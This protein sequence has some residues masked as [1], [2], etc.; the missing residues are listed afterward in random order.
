VATVSLCTFSD[1]SPETNEGS[2]QDKV[3][4]RRQ[5]VNDEKRRVASAETRLREFESPSRNTLLTSARV[6]HIGTRQDWLTEMRKEK[7]ADKERA[8]H[9]KSPLKVTRQRTDIAQQYA[10]RVRHQPRRH[11][12]LTNNT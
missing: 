2:C 11:L 10:V 12:L 5:A 8:G 9:K 7:S 1:Y 6:V 3:K 4:A